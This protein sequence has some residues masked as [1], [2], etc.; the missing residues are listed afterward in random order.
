M[1]IVKDWVQ[2]FLPGANFA[3]SFN[4]QPTVLF[5]DV[6]FQTDRITKGFVKSLPGFGDR[7]K[8]CRMGTVSG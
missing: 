8:F 5:L 2:L 6:M 3:A 4:A 1:W 7:F